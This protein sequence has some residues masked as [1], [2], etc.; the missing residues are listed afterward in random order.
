LQARRC[1]AMACDPSMELKFAKFW[2]ATQAGSSFTRALQGRGEFADP[3]LLESVRTTFGLPE[4]STGLPPAVFDPR[5][6]GAEEYFDA[7]AAAQAVAGEAR[8][9]AHASRTAVAFVSAGTQLEAAGAPA[10]LWR[11]VGGAPPAA[12]AAAPT[13]APLREGG[14]PTDGA[15]PPPQRRSRWE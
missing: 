10:G 11:G 4:H 3:Y 2:A 12:A 1:R 7:L 15:Q 9:A 14:R 8:A 13:F 6:Y 5:G